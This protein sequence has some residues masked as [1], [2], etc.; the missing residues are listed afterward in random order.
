M[1]VAVVGAGIAGL[2]AARELASLGAEA[3]VF[4]AQQSTGGRALTYSRDGFVADMGVQTYTPRGMHLENAIRL[5]GEEALPIA[6]EIFLHAEG[7]SIPGSPERNQAPRYTFR[8]G[9]HRL[10]EILAEG[11]DVRLGV[12]IQ[13]IRKVKGVFRLA[14][15]EVDAVIL[16]PPMPEIER[17]LRTAGDKRN[18]SGAAY[19]PC[20]SVALAYP[21]TLKPR[22]YYALLAEDRMEPVLWVGIENLKCPGRAPAGWTLLVAQ[23]GPSYS[24]SHFTT[25]DK[26]VVRTVS[27]TVRRIFGD[28]LGEPEWFHIVRWAQSQP[29][30]V[31]LF[32]NANHQGG[33]LIVAGDGTLAGRAENA[34]E[35]GLKAAHLAVERV[36][37]TA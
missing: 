32:D 6:G 28:E 23:T 35:T 9:N 19:R 25:P 20:I 12:P 15:E 1:R 11:L 8:R 37:G 21:V 31:V 14:Q 30:R 33:R 16:T 13:E 7:R 24:R 17:L 3:V 22:P 4:E 10:A 26:S 2:G 34:Y 29:E 5:A 27:R 18:L 36:R